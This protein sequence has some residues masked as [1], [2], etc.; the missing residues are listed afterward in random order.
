MP[1]RNVDLRCNSGRGVLDMGAFMILKPCLHCI[2]K[3]DCQRRK[4]ILAAIK[5]SGLMWGSFSC[6][7]RWK[8]FPIGLRI[9]YEFSYAGSEHYDY[10]G[11]GYKESAEIA[12]T[13]MGYKQNKIIV[14]LDEDPT[15]GRW[16]VKL[17]PDR[18]TILDEPLRQCC[19][20]CHKPDGE[21]NSKEWVCPMCDS[22][23]TWE[24]INK[25]NG[26]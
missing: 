23:L 25:R 5:G 9:S 20:V 3:K 18:V 12:G 24:E 1:N 14:W 2:F 22:G 11:S 19:P 15:E 16:I 8:A 21:E 10:N 13:I 4:D 6:V 7:E 26:I 17:W